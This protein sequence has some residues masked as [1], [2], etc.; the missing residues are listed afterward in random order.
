MTVNKTFLILLLASVSYTAY[1]AAAVSENFEISTTIDHEIVLGNLRTASTDA[2]VR[3]TGDISL[4]TIV[5]DSEYTEWSNWNYSDTGIIHFYEQGGIISADNATLGYFTANVPNP[6]ECDT[7]PMP[8]CA[9][10]TILTD[11]K[12]GYIKNLFGSSKGMNTCSFG[13]K[14]SGSSNNFKVIPTDCVLSDFKTTSGTHTGTLTI[15]YT[16][17]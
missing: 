13:I 2:D 12:Y 1:N 17:S 11:D 4:G 16:P 14:Y 15:S 7:D 8:A 3:K 6:E 5:I 10:L 9:G